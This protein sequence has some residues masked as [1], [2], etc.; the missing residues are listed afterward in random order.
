MRTYLV[1]IV[2]EE[3]TASR[4]KVRAKMQDPPPGTSPEVVEDSFTRERL[5]ETL[6]MIDRTLSDLFDPRRGIYVPKKARFDSEDAH[7]LFYSW[8]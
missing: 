7:T 3:S 2:P 4:I 5:E 8:D 1:S 6:A